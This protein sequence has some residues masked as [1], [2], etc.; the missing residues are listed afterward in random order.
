MAETGFNFDYKQYLKLI[1]LRRYVFTG[2]LLAVVT[3]SVL[4]S[5]LMPYQYMASTIVLVEA[6]PVINPL[7][8]DVNPAF[9]AQQRMAML[10]QLLFNRRN[11]ERV[12]QKL[13]L[14]INADSPIKFESLIKDIQGNLSASVRGSNL[15]QVNYIGDDPKVVRDIVN[16]LASQ[17]IEDNLQ[18]KR[19]GSALSIEFHGEQLKEY[20]EKLEV[21]EVA[22]KNFKIQNASFLSKRGGATLSRIQNYQTTLMNN[23][24]MVRELSARKELL[25]KQL[26]GKVPFVEVTD[27]K[28][29]FS[30]SD[31][32]SVLERNLSF[33]LLKYTD[34]YPDVIKTRAE[35][36]GLKKTLGEQ[37]KKKSK[38][39]ASSS[40]KALEESNSAYHKLKEEIA[41]I[42]SEVSSLIVKGEELQIEVSMLEASLEGIPGEEHELIKLER[43]VRVYESIYS[44]LL[45][46]LEE[47][48]ITREMESKEESVIFKVIDPAVIPIRPARPDRVVYMLFGLL[49][50]IVGGVGAVFVRE[51]YLDTSFKSLDDIKGAISIPVIAT[52]PT[53]STKAGS[54][55]SRKRDIWVFSITAFYIFVVFGLIIR[56]T[57]LKYGLGV[58]PWGR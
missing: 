4:V 55:V 49:A 26:S 45:G 21:A 53:I 19:K 40:G 39:L 58:L 9:R 42:D 56:E 10:K 18:L 17:Y 3:A 52:I 31:R 51:N 20:A 50:G 5:Y 25:Q 12:A 6:S 7:N 13:D 54:M 22:L 38:M 33:L 36:E 41:S 43:D 24:L 47:A 30:P 11:I 44:T 28:K 8:Q 37:N 34:N 2:A 48:N 46:K 32:L 23:K 57:L 15:F 16:T 29:D 35:I 14:D 27:P 1:I